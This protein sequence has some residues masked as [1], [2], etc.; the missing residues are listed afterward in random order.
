MGLE[1]SGL[2]KRATGL[3]ASG[4]AGSLLVSQQDWGGKH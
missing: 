4:A 3:Q 1:W 2:A